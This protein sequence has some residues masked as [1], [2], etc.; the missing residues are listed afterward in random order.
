MSKSCKGLLKELYACLEKSDCVQVRAAAAGPGST[1]L[2]RCGLMASPARAG[3]QQYGGSMRQDGAGAERGVQGAALHVHTLQEGHA[4]HAHAHPWQS[5]ILVRCA[6]MPPV[7]SDV[8]SL[9][10][11]F[12]GLMPSAVDPT[13]NRTWLTTGNEHG[14]A[15]YARVV[16]TAPSCAAGRLLQTEGA[17]TG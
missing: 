12:V 2:D 15:A 11:C 10:G 1:V 5:R 4:G 14:H 13:G 16:R 9:H 7:P 8:R 17:R 3:A 6:V